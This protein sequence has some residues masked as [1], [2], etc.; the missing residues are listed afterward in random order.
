MKAKYLGKSRHKYDDAV[1]LF[2]EY[3]GKEYMIT[4]EHN[5]YSETMGEK[6]RQAQEEIDKELDGKET[7]SNSEPFDF[8]ILYNYW[9][10]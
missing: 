6:H 1:D 4:D 3:R 2:Y 5:G 7:I 10:D 9:E 8:S